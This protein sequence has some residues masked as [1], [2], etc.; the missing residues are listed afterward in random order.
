MTPIDADLVGAIY[1]AA[2]EPSRWRTCL[3]AFCRAFDAFYGQLGVRHRDRPERSFLVW[4][5]IDD[6]RLQR[7]IPRYVE[8]SSSDWTDARTLDDPAYPAR[9]NAR[10]TP[11]RLAA[12]HQGAAYHGDELATNDELETAA[13]VREIR[14]PLD[15]VRGLESTQGPNENNRKR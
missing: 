5:G 6:A 8:L 12:I 7:Y 14:R 11:E 1:D 15:L 10:S 9:L 2:L 13:V 3:A 4:H